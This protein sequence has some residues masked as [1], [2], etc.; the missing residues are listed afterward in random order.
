MTLG[1]DRKSPLMPPVWRRAAG[2]DPLGYYIG[3]LAYADLQVLAQAVE[4]VGSLGQEKLADYL[5]THTFHTVAGDI[6][7]GP[8]GEWARPR[9][10]EVQFQGVQGHD[11][12]QFKDAKTEVILFPPEYSSGTLR[13]PYGGAGQ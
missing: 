11:L 1:T 8:N 9:V 2:V 5:R 7:F 10:L 3:P 6:S 13:A 4:G 12:A